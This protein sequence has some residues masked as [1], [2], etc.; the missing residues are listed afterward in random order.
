VQR[1]QPVAQLE[2][3]EDVALDVEVT[4]DVGAAEAELARCGDEATQRVGG[5][6]HERR[7]RV[8]R[9]GAA[10]VVGAEADRQVGSENRGDQVRDGRL[11]GHAEILKLLSRSC[12][13]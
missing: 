4:G 7:R 3:G 9:P 2:R 6:E 11:A 10:A 13:A 12:E 1:G 8:V 5:S